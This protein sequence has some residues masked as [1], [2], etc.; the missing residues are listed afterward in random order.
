MDGSSV[1]PSAFGVTWSQMRS[2]RSEA[3]MRPHAEAL[4]RRLLSRAKIVSRSPVPASAVAA[5]LAGAAVGVGKLS[6]LRFGA[7]GFAVA[8]V[9]THECPAAGVLARAGGFDVALGAPVKSP[10]IPLDRMAGASMKKPLTD[11]CGL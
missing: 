3:V 2:R 4:W 7:V 6:D 9:V 11:V 5:G 10:D 8:G 1:P